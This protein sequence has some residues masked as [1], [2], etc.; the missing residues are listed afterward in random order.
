M[1]SL[2]SLISRARLARFILLPCACTL[3]AAC[4]SEPIHDNPG[5]QPEPVLALPLRFE[6]I[7]LVGEPDDLTD[8]VFLPDGEEMLVMSKVGELYHYRLRGEGD[9]APVTAEPLGRF[10]LSNVSSETDCGAISLVLDNAF[11]ENG[12]FF[13]S[14]CTSRQGSGVYRYRFDAGDYGAI[15]GSEVLVIEAE[16]PAAQRAWHNVGS[17]NMDAQG[18]LWV[19]FGDKTIDWHAQ[20]LADNLGAIVRIVPNRDRNGS[21]YE[22]ALDNPFAGEEDKSADIYA[23]GVRSPYRAVLDGE[24]RLWFGDVGSAV[25]EEINVI[26]RPG[27]NFG[28]SNAEGTCQENCADLTDPVFT[29]DRSGDHDFIVEDPEAP[30]INARVATAGLAYD[31]SLHDRYAGL[32][33]DRVIY[34]DMCVGFLRAARFSDDHVVSDEYVG[35]LRTVASLRQSA[36]GYIYALSLGNCQTDVTRE[37]DTTSRLFRALPTVVEP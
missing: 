14:K 1:V 12:W 21:G 29:W 33:D 9:A 11:E 17:L 2:A 34:G 27:Q 16:E 35:H 20:E 24:G 15:D 37:I 22:P 6:P 7:E 36:D 31:A 23:Y 8:F 4:T 10:Q 28:W 25:A 3:L 18:H 5:Q 32:L 30:A 13:V 19:P 26:T